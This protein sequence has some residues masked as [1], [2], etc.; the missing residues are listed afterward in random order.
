MTS[1]QIRSLVADSHIGG[2]VFVG[3]NAYAKPTLNW[4]TGPF[5]EAFREG[6]WDDNLDKWAVRWECRDFARAFAC[7]A[8]RANALTSSVPPE[9][10]ALTVGEFWFHPDGESSG[11]A[12]NICITDAG[13][14][15]IEPQT[16]WVRPVTSTELASAYMTRF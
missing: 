7:E 14:V 13:L 10:D 8:Q 12:I 6:L 16:G 11:H 2:P 15:F 9:D 3:G 5:Y 1:D 4:L